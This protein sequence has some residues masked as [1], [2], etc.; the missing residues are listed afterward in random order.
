MARIARHYGH[1]VNEGNCC[2]LPVNDVLIVGAHQKTPNHGAF[3]VEIHDL[4]RVLFKD[5][6]KPGVKPLRLDQIAATP[7]PFDATL[8]FANYLD[9]EVYFIPGPV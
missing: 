3:Q 1:I 2:N 4:L 6:T 7:K 5:E 9:G 8:E